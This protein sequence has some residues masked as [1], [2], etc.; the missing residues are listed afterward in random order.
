M[1][2]LYNI[3]NRQNT[4]GSELTQCFH[5]SKANLKTH[6]VN[7]PQL[8][9]KC[10]GTLEKVR[11]ENTIHR[12]KNGRNPYRQPGKMDTYPL[13]QIG[14][15]G[16]TSLHRKTGNGSMNFKTDCCRRNYK[17]IRIT[18]TARLTVS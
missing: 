15:T 18:A 6:F 16:G 3:I 10:K 13:T 2:F 14:R 9:V 4:T 5:A 7:S 1:I 11:K 12:R 8:D 17:N